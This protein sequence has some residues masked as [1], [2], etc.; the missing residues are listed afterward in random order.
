M[1]V[2]QFSEVLKT[3]GIQKALNFLAKYLN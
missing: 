2:S 1:D 3:E